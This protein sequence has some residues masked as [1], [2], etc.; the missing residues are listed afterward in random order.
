M[1][2]PAEQVTPKPAGVPWE[3]AGALYVAGGAAWAGIVATEPRAGETVVVSGASGGVGL[4]SVQLV[5]ERGARVVALSSEANRE[6]LEGLGATWVDY[7]PGETL[8]DRVRAAAGGTPDAWIDDFGDGYVQLAIEL[9][10]PADRINTIIDYAAVEQ[11]G[12]KGLGSHQVTDAAV[13]A[14]LLQRVDD[15]RLTRADRLDLPAGAGAGRDARGGAAT[16]PRQDRPAAL[17]CR[18]GARALRRPGCRRTRA[19]RSRPS[20][21]RCARGSDRGAA[22]SRHRPAS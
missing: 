10:V 5:R 6:F 8:G 12:V 2:V 18:T 7:S 20:G 19:A 13:L 9:G 1:V 15:G 3:V 22:R 11:Y 21:P 4:I 14:Q 16:D 17:T